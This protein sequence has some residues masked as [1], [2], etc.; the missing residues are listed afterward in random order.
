[1]FHGVPLATK[2]ISI[3][4]YIFECEKKFACCDRETLILKLLNRIE[5]FLTKCYITLDIQL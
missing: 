5:K 2:Y 3:N 4:V 1:M